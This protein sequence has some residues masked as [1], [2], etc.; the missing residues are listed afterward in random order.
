MSQPAITTPAPPNHTGPVE[1]YLEPRQP[2]CPTG[3]HHSHSAGR[4][5]HIRHSGELPEDVARHW[6]KHRLRN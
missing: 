3:L 1:A 6:D 5:P 4:P 2:F